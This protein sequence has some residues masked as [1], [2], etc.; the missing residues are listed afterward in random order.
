MQ[1]SFAPEHRVEHFRESL[2]NLL[3]WGG[4]SDERTGHLHTVRWNFTDGRLDIVGNPVNEVAAVFALDLA[5]LL[6]HFF[7]GEFPSKHHGDSEELSVPRIA[8][9]H[10]VFRVEHL[11]CQ[12]TS[13]R[14][15]Y[16]KMQ[17]LDCKREGAIILYLYIILNLFFS[18]DE[19]YFKIY[20]CIFYYKE[21]FDIIFVKKM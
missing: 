17:S 11:K 4:V 6:F 8:G 18:I 5:Y 14:P 12:M 7:H 13:K 9:G 2:E 16:I 3:N 10:H 20:W 21:V 1:E 15:I 19:L